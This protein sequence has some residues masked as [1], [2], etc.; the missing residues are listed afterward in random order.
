M[1]ST[2][3][4]SYIQARNHQCYYSCTLSLGPVLYTWLSSDLVSYHGRST[5]YWENEHDRYTVAH[6][7]VSKKMLVIFHSHVHNKHYI[8]WTC[9]LVL[10]HSASHRAISRTRLHPSCHIP[11]NLHKSTLTLICTVYDRIDAAATINFSTQ[12]GG[13]YSRA[14][15]ILRAASIIIVQHGY[16]LKR[17]SVKN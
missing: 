13:Y 15:S 5:E 1:S 14:A 2:R 17:N 12:F 6:P 16:G 10:E 9:G 7:L 3:C 11:R 8:F 4:R